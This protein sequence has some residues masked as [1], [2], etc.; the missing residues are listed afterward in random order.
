MSRVRFSLSL[1]LLPAIGCS[2][3]HVER[4]I[5]RH[6]VY[7]EP[8]GA[9]LSL[10]D[11]R[12]ALQLGSSNAEVEVEVEVKERRFSGWLS[13]LLTG[14]SLALGGAGLGLGY[15]SESGAL[16]ISGGVFALAGLIAT[17]FTLVEQF[18]K[19]RVVSRTFVH[20]TPKIAAEWETQSG[21]RV[22]PNEHR[23]VI[24][25]ELSPSAFGQAVLPTSVNRPDAPKPSLVAVFPVE[26]RSAILDTK[27]ARELS[28]YFEV[29]I[30][31]GSALRVVPQ[32]DL[33]RLLR[34][35]KA[36]SFSPCFDE[37]CQIEVGKALAAEKMLVT[38]VLRLGDG[39][40]F[41]ATL[42]DLRSEAS[43]SAHSSRSACSATGLAV[44]AEEVAR[45]V[46][47][48]H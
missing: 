29:R 5:E 42:F 21:L 25:P 30:A 39:C 16:F 9:R 27:G 37:S 24:R 48:G 32:A 7:S 6:S 13:W 28:D 44:A 3:M 19:P 34:Q 15:A 2:H 46:A 26:V 17:P 1:L 36:K 8:E 12:G 38:R 20:G 45:S 14:G 18:K 33:Q 43:E 22:V 41:T 47:H 31:S 35:E 10:V 40:A 4:R 11:E 23:F